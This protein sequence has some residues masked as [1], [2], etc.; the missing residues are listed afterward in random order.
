MSLAASVR[1]SPASSIRA[2]RASLARSSSP[3]DDGIRLTERST[4]FIIRL[5]HA[6]AAAARVAP[7]NGLSSR[8]RVATG[9]V[10]LRAQPRSR[11]VA[12][13]APYTPLKI[14]AVRHLSR[15][16]K[17][18]SLCRSTPRSRT[19]ACRFFSTT[20]TTTTTRRLHRAEAARSRARNARVETR[21]DSSNDSSLARTDVDRRR[22]TRV[23]S[24]SVVKRRRLTRSALSR[25][26][27]FSFLARKQVIPSLQGDASTQSPPDLPSFIF[28]ERIVYLGMTLVPSVTELI[29]AELLYLQYEDN[30]K[31]IYLYINSTGTSKEGQKYGYDTEAFA[32]YDTMKYVNPPVHT[33]A[34]GT[35]WGEAAMLLACGEKGHRAALPSASIMIKQPIN[36]FR[37]QATELEIQRKEIRNTKRQTLELLSK[38]IGRD[39]EEIEKDINRPKYFN[40]WEAVEYGIID[41]VLDGKH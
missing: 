29:L 11:T 9:T 20:T 10:A 18:R 15:N 32:I 26:L 28:K 30:N 25:L 37:G 33:V 40:P 41:Q 2:N 6:Q 34:V 3:L 38:G 14:N 16:L 31:P 21:D 27:R 39:Y 36:A 8:R 5:R 13:S 24:A 35:A 19:T 7:R 23:S 22:R 17:L 12:R 1:V 4:A